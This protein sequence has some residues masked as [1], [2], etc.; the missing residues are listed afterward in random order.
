[1]PVDAILPGLGNH[2]KLYVL[3]EEGPEEREVVVGF[4]NDEE[5]Q[6]LSGL[7][8]GEEVVVNPEE[9][10]EQRGVRSGGATKHR[11]TRRR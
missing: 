10:T 8:E 6:I 5:A 2:R 9:L 3:K 4:S 7:Q 1:V 11:R